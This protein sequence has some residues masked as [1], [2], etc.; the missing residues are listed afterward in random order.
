MKQLINICFFCAFANSLTAQVI[1]ATSGAVISVQSGTILY[2]DGNIA[3][4]NGSTLNNAG[5]VTINAATLQNNGTY[6]GTGTLNANPFTNNGSVVPGNNVGTLTF[7]NNFTNAGTLTMDI[8]SATLFDKLVV[9]GTATAGGTLSVNFG[10]YAP[11]TGQT[12]QIISATAYAGNFSS[13][14]I[15]PNTIP[16]M[17]ANGV[18]TI[19][20]VLPIDLLYFTGKNEG[21]VNVLKWATANLSSG[22]HD[23]VNNKGFEIQRLNSTTQRWDVL[24]FVPAQR[25]D[26]SRLYDFMDKMPFGI[27]YYRLRQI[28]NDGKATF[29]NIVNIVMEG[30][31]SLSVY[32]NPAGDDLTVQYNGD[33]IDLSSGT[34]DFEIFNIVGQSVLQGKI[35]Q[36]V[37]VSRLAAGTYIVKVGAEQVKFVKQ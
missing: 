18:L 26:A 11:T 33:A 13:L 15:T 17:Y 6:A 23:E 9:N 35:R 24:G 22:T 2:A 1:K 19:S 36:S 25:R 32:P 28:D 8:S 16:A 14:S 5:T 29:S 30:K 12:F 3:L 4:D 20:S 34:H 10:S 37:D 31:T 27:S 7:N 21:R